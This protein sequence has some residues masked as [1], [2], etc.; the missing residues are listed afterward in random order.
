MNER[1][2]AIRPDRAL[3]VLDAPAPVEP[4]SDADFLSQLIAERQQ[5]GPQRERRRASIGAATRT[6]ATG[7][8]IAVRRVPAG[9]RTSRFV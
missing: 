7:A 3:V 4:R 5:L 9:Y 2:R 8:N 1:D 6:Y